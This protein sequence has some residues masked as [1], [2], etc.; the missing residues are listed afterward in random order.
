MLSTILSSDA[1]VYAFGVIIVALVL[2][3]IRISG[4]LIYIRHN[5][6]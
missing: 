3:L 2:L 5:P 1:G 4:A 6:V